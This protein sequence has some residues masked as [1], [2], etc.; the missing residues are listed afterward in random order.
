[1][2]LELFAAKGFEPWFAVP[3]R[4]K[5]NLEYEATYDWLA[6]VPQRDSEAGALTKYSGTGRAVY[7]V[8]GNK[9]AAMEVGINTKFVV[10]L[11]YVLSGMLAALGGLLYTGFLGVAP[12]I[13]GQNDVFPAFAAAVIGGVSLFGGR[14]HVIGAVGGV[15]LLATIELGLI[16]MGVEATAVDVVLLFAILIYTIE[17]R[18]RRWIITK[19]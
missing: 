15:I 1:V 14:G 10:I 18:I 19:S 9:K 8:G 12:P 16:L 7:A 17:D 5:T 4:P 3:L 13:I 11:V 2:T 6:L